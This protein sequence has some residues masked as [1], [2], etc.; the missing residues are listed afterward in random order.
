[1][2]NIYAT[3]IDSDYSCITTNEPKM[4]MKTKTRESIHAP[5][6]TTLQRA[7]S[8]G[9]PTLRDQNGALSPTVLRQG[10]STVA[11]SISKTM[12]MT[13]TFHEQEMFMTL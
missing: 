5:P 2:S 7:P 4:E 11:M 3:I 10:D 12:K 6:L 1:M 13:R 8:C 9:P